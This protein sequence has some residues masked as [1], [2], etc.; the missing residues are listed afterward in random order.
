MPVIQRRDA[1]V[2]IALVFTLS[3]AHLPL[4]E[5]DI[6]VTLNQ[7]RPGFQHLM[8]RLANNMRGWHAHQLPP[9]RVNINDPV[10]RI[11]HQHPIAHILDQQI[12]PHR[13]N[14]QHPEAEQSPGHRK[15][16]QSER[17]GGQIDQGKWLYA[18][19]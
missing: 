8:G 17:V 10:K 14:I 9:R 15:P 4:S 12:A 2:I 6:A 7:L 1:Q 16:G 19:D 13:H 18:R 5:G 3:Q 11:Q